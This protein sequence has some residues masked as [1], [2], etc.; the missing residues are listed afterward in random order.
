VGLALSSLLNV[1]EAQQLYWKATD[2]CIEQLIRLTHAQPNTV[3]GWMF[4]NRKKWTFLLDWLEIHPIPPQDH[5]GHSRLLK[6]APAAA[7]PEV[8]RYGVYAAFGASSA[9]KKMCL[10]SI[11]SGRMF[12]YAYEESDDDP[13]EREFEK[14]Q[15]IDCQ[16]SVKKWCLA[17]VKDVSE[18]Q[19]LVHYCDW[20]SKW[21]EWIDK[22]SSR[23]APMGKHT[24]FK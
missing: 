7:G 1:I 23:L 2:Y 17:E 9:R 16:D 15:I 20:D 10:E 22:T 5:R 12:E 19:V 3:G 6:P 21:D 13:L 11:A 24:A 18:R 4:A 14:D 8:I